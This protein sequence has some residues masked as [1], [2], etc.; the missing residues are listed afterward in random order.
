MAPKL[1]KVRSY[2]APVHR[3]SSLLHALFW[4]FRVSEMPSQMLTASFRLALPF[5]A[6]SR[7]NSRLSFISARARHSEKQAFDF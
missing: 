5:L 3:V 2:R 4:K 1:F 6:R 7:T